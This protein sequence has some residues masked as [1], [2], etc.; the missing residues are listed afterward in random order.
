MKTVY[1]IESMIYPHTIPGPLEQENHIFKISNKLPYY[2]STLIL[3]NSVHHRIHIGTV[4]H[5]ENN[6]KYSIG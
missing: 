2:S 6:I 5:A 1:T 4:L 3:P